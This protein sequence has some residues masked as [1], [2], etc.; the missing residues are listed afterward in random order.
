MK[1]ILW[2]G[3]IVGFI[4]LLLIISLIVLNF[5][6]VDLQY[7]MAAIFG[8]A[9]AEEVGD[10]LVNITF[11]ISLVISVFLTS[12]FVIIKRGKKR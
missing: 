7:R 4:I 12:L 10:M 1:V 3:R 6:P 9:G 5:I 8:I 2:S 11:I